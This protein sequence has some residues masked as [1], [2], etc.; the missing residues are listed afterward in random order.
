MPRVVISQ[1]QEQKRLDNLERL[2]KAFPDKEMLK[3]KEVQDYTGLCYQ[4]V[5]KLFS[6]NKCN[7]ISKATL[8]RELAQ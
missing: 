8:S 3:V 5:K 2:D 4:T 6:F 7:V 1:E